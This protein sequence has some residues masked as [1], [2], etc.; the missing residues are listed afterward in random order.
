MITNPDP[1][2][3]WHR[4]I[5]EFISSTSSTFLKIRPLAVWKYNIHLS[6]TDISLSFELVGSGPGPER[7]VSKWKVR[8]RS[9]NFPMRIKAKSKWPWPIRIQTK[10]RPKNLVRVRYAANVHWPHVLPGKDGAEHGGRGKQA[11]CHT[12][13]DSWRRII[14][15]LFLCSFLPTKDGD[16]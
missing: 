14:K 7:T 16:S 15:I 2:Y 12:R 5:F 3:D 11:P 8:S 1:K 13:P 10:E 6:C 4:R 9:R